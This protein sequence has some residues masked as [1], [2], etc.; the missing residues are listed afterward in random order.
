MG[1]IHTFINLLKNDP[2]G[3]FIQ[4]GEIF[5]RTRASRLINDA[6]YLKIR[7]KLVFGSKLHLNNPISFNE[8][9]QWL[10][11]YNRTTDKT[12]M[13]GKATSKQYASNLI[14]EEHVIPTIG[15]YDSFSEIDRNSLPR[16]FVIKCTHDSG[17]I[18]ICSDKQLFDWDIAENKINRCLNRSMFWWGREWPYKGVKPQIIIE[19][20]MKDGDNDF[21]PV[22]KFLCF[23]GIPKIIQTIQNDKQPNESID[24]FDTNWNLLDMRQNYPNSQSPLKRPELLPEMLEIATKLAVDQPFVRVDL[25]TINGQI[26]FSEFTFFSDCGFA[27][28]NPES[29]DLEWGNW[30][31]LPQKTEVT[32]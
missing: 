3:V 25:Y 18:V 5:A 28:F 26:F 27:R 11:L 13:V 20:F 10:K 24:Y 6:A 19:P 12:I 14:G 15:V 9:M 23:N 29:I 4:L 17:S 7:Y 31:K 32:I 16:Q 8:K 2:Q 21:L 22:Y 1:K 30:I